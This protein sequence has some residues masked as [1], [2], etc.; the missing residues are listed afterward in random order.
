MSGVRQFLQPRWLFGHLLVVLAVL[1]CLRLG[2]WQVDRSEEADGT[3]QNVGYAVL[4]PLFGVAFVY[5]WIK[6]L[7]LESQR[8]DADEAAHEQS[9]S[10]VLA[11]ADAITAEA[12]G[13]RST[14]VPPAE[15]AP[16][17]TELPVIDLDS[18]LVDDDTDDPELAAYNRALAALAEE[19]RRAR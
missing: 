2:W 6:F 8:A 9:L 5:M 17:P 3:L 13:A 4:W 7:R 19:D 16:E 18:P 15:P 11:E 12:A 10:L 1:V 14:A